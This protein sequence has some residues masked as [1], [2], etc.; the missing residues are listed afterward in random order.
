VHV[1]ADLADELI[2]MAEEDLAAQGPIGELV[3]RDPRFKAWVERV[4][5]D[6]RLPLSL[7]VWD[8]GEPPA[9]LVA[10]HAILDRHDLRLA[11]IVDGHGWPGRALVGEDGADAAWLLAQH[12]DRHHSLRE[13]WLEAVA[14]AV[15]RHDAD[16]RHLAR[17]ADRIAMIN[18]D[19][20][21]FGTYAE[22]DRAA[23]TITWL[24]PAE[25][26]LTDVDRCRREIGLP[27]LRDDLQ[28]PE[29]AGPYRYRR[30]TA[31][32]AWPSHHPLDSPS[33]AE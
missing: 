2:D 23:D 17:L 1:N 10:A 29:G 18:G 6:P 13:G 4:M 28:E 16:P 30:T 31:A 8:D 7:A 25:G 24:F 12:C 32:Y 15:A 3:E 5:T 22:L 20:Q 27:P 14:D 21:R 9:E 19:G 33:P 26:S 11:E